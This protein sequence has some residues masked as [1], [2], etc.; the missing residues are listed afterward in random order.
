MSGPPFDLAQAHR[1]FAVE[2]NN[3][4]WDLDEAGERS[5]GERGRMLHLAHAAL[6]HW[7]QVGTALQRLR[8]L[9]L[10][11]TAYATAGFAQPAQQYADETLGELAADIEGATPFD[12][13]SAY[14]SAALAYSLPPPTYESTSPRAHDLA[15]QAAT[16]AAALNAEDRAVFNQLYARAA[17][18]AT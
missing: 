15:Q 5:A 18:P 1:W 14:A 11:T 6:F 13:A 2:C 7:S 4:A 17:P 10:L 8:A 3:R 12:H 16:L 9:T